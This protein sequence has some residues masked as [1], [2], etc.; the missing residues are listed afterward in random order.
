MGLIRGFWGKGGD[1]KRE[2]RRE[3]RKKN[4]ERED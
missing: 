3:V 1:R 4:E 2:K